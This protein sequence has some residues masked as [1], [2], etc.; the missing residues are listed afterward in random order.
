M[1]DM[2]FTYELTV[3][4]LIAFSRYHYANSKTVKR[5]LLIGRLLLVVIVMT[6]GYLFDDA[7][8]YHFALVIAALLSVI[9][10]L[11]T[12][13]KQ[14]EALERAARNQYA[15]GAN[16]GVLGRKTLSLTDAGFVIQGETDRHEQAFAAVERVVRTDSHTFLYI[17]AANAHVIP[18]RDVEPVNLDAM[19]AAIAQHTDKPI[20]T[21]SPTAPPPSDAKPAPLHDAMAVFLR[22]R[23]IACPACGYNLRGQSRSSCAE[24]GATLRLTVDVDP[25]PAPRDAWMGTFMFSSLLLG[26]QFVLAASAAWW[27]YGMAKLP[28]FVRDGVLGFSLFAPLWVLLLFKARRAFVTLSRD[29]QVVW[30]WVLLLFQTLM[31]L[32]LMS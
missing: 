12:P 29:T 4:D 32:L 31:I 30:V 13:K 19:H 24:C 18:H 22:N 11:L 15:E 25:P 23:D 26:M 10:L 6:V 2:S 21:S 14:Y 17:G 5:Q 9:F 20:E 1:S 16:R 7:L 27:G 28:S 3:D 8:P